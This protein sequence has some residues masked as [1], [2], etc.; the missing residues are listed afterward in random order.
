MYRRRSVVPPSVPGVWIRVRRIAASRI[1]ISAVGIRSVR[2]SSVRVRR[3]GASRIR[4]GRGSWK[5]H[6]RIWIRIRRRIARRRVRCWGIPGRSCRSPYRLAVCRDTIGCSVGGLPVSCRGSSD[7]RITGQPFHPRVV[8]LIKRRVCRS[9][10]R[11]HRW[12]CHGCGSRSGARTK[13]GGVRVVRRG[14]WDRVDR[15][16]RRDR[17]QRGCWERGGSCCRRGGRITR[18]RGKSPRGRRGKRRLTQSRCSGNGPKGHTEHESAQ[19]SELGLLGTRFQTHRKSKGCRQV[20]WRRAGSS[21]P[22]CEAHDSNGC[23]VAWLCPSSEL[24]RIRRKA[25]F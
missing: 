6:S 7:G 9:T 3:I 2:T 11:S 19:E 16:C 18:C 15:R 22:A 20:F 1:R 12:A 25:R 14:R 5:K 8:D 23:S 13:R 17:G 24:E 4:T 21:L 10:V